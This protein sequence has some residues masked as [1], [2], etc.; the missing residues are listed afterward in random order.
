M[1]VCISGNT[2]FWRNDPFIQTGHP[3][4]GNNLFGANRRDIKPENIL[5]DTRGR[6]KIAD[7]GIAK[8]LGEPKKNITL[9]ASG[10]VVGTPNYMAP[11]QLENP[12]DVDQR[13]DIY[14]LGVVFYEMLTGEL[15]IG[16][17]APPSQK[18]AVDPRVDEV[19]L[20]ALEKE[21]EKRYHSAGEVK[22]SVEEITAHPA[23]AVARPAATEVLPMRRGSCYFS[24]PERMRNCFP[25]PQAQIFQCKGELRLELES[26]TFISPWQTR[27]VIPLKEIR[28]LSIGQFQMWVGPWG[29]KNEK[30]HFLAI[31]YGSGS[32]QRIV[33]LTTIPAAKSAPALINAQVAEWFESVCKAVVAV[34]GSSP[35]ALAPAAVTI[36]A[37]GSWVRRVSRLLVIAPV[38]AWLVGVVSIKSS[39]GPA[40]LAPWLAAVLVALLSCLA[41]AWFAFGFLKAN[42]ALQ[43]GDLDAVTADEPPGDSSDSVGGDVPVLGET[44]AR[45]P[46]L[47]FRWA[48]SAWILL[49]LGVMA[50]VD[51]LTGLYSRPIHQTFYPGIAQLFAGIALL[52]LSRR[53]RLVALVA[54]ALSVAATVFITVMLVIS[55]A[56]GSVSIPA[57]N[58]SNPATALP[59]LAA[60][61]V[62][63]LAV[64]IG[65]PCYLLLSAKGRAFFGSAKS[66]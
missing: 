62:V 54:L 10:M 46:K 36:R 44:P 13:A 66:K 40:P 16:R 52:T 8:L 58:I 35:H 20:H 25:G 37:H 24:T 15:P 28:E 2:D 9:T 1:S 60:T 50:L 32:Q 17:F 30:V 33:H 14:S 42:Q 56:Q 48:L 31:T 4:P 47:P 57:L 39:F 53:W 6:V 38:A 45:K 26:L 29:M 18:S 64:A 41:L 3:R 49:A 34:T 22:T 43:T 7:F 65:W 63:F 55:P 5:L 23:A 12:R 61:A 51:T 19:V 27:V 11:E 59:R 21:R